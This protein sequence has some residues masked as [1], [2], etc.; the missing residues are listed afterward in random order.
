[1]LSEIVRRRVLKRKDG[2]YSGVVLALNGKVVVGLTESLKIGASAYEE[3]KGERRVEVKEFDLLW[4]FDLVRI[5]HIAFVVDG[6][7][8]AVYKVRVQIKYKIFLE[9]EEIEGLVG[10]TANDADGV[11]TR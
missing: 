4:E 6:S 5:V 7:D 8:R 3:T 10:F 2:L 11:W 9:G 1:M